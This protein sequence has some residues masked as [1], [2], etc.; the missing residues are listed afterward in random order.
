MLDPKTAQPRLAG[1]TLSLLDL[2][3]S[4]R[5]KP[6]L[7]W[8]THNSG[9]DAF[10][11]LFAFQKLLD[12]DNTPTPTIKKPRTISTAGNVL[13]PSLPMTPMQAMYSGFPARGPKILTQRSVSPTT[14]FEAGSNRQV[15]SRNLLQTHSLGRPDDSDAQ[16]I[17][18]KDKNRRSGDEYE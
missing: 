15:T 12:P 16:T 1:T 3:D 9:N 5:L 7:H 4:F 6:E 18:T 17:K 8:Q 10:M 13:I 11:A 2:I 14:Y